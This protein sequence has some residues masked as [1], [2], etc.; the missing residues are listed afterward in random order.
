MIIGEVHNEQRQAILDEFNNNPESKICILSSAGQYGLNITTASVVVNYDLPFSL[1]KLE[2]R[3]GRAHR[4]GQKRNVMV[5]NLLG[6]GTADMAIKKI[7]HSKTAL[8]GQILGDTP[9]TMENIREML[10]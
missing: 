8:S 6:K 5:Y 4:I 1:S 3:I 2:Q 7:I 9:V 10:A